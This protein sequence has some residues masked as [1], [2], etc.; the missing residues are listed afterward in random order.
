MNE[1]DYLVWLSYK[2]SRRILFPEG[3]TTVG[4]EVFQAPICATQA[5]CNLCS[6]GTTIGIRQRNCRWVGSQ[7]IAVICDYTNHYTSAG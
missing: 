3:A 5:L 7:T 4:S 1:R 6:V 2:S